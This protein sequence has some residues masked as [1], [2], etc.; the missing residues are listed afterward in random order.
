MTPLEEFETMDLNLEILSL[1]S[2]NHLRREYVKNYVLTENL[3]RYCIETLG[4][5]SHYISEEIFKKRGYNVDAGTIID[6][7][8]EKNIK[9]FSP[10]EA[11]NNHNVRKKY[12][13]TCKKK[14]GSNNALS[15]NTSAYKKRN[16]TVKNKYGV[17]NVFQLQNVKEK[18]KATMLERYGVNHTIYMPETERN[19]GRRSK[20]HQKIENILKE[21]N[22]I[23]ESEV[24]NKFGMFNQQLGREFSPIV[25]I[26][27]ESKKIVIEINGDMW[28]ANPLKYKSSD[29]IFKWNSYISAGEIW[30][31]DEIRNNQIKNFGYDV[32]VIWEY[33]IR[34]NFESVNK[35]LYEKIREN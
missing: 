3:I 6:F 5:S 28:H 7:C 16:N 30:K 1:P 8:K 23:F 21:N 14:Y 11:A 4:L 24:K 29:K 33:D 22:I 27:I 25:D 2:Q 34:K 26:L 12:I 13:D 18:S 35:I 31:L 9:T 32:I 10:K 15:K 19:Y 17:E 20:I